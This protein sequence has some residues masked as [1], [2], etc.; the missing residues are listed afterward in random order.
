M[1]RE[2]IRD[3]GGVS[4]YGN[5]GQQSFCVHIDGRVERT[6]SYVCM[7]EEDGLIDV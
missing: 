2:D 5:R 7:H 4:R 6:Y 3:H 1:I